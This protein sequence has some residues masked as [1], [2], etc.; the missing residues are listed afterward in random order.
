VEGVDGVREKNL[1][2]CHQS[3]TQVSSCQHT[4]LGLMSSFPDDISPGSYV[5]RSVHKRCNF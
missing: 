4:K 2:N 3:R 5:F 1:P